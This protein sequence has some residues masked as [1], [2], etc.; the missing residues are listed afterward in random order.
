MNISHLKIHYIWNCKKCDAQFTELNLTYPSYLCCYDC[1]TLCHIDSAFYVQ[2][3]AKVPKLN[4]GIAPTE[5]DLLNGIS[6]KVY[7][8]S[9]RDSQNERRPDPSFSVFSKINDEYNLRMTALLV[10]EKNKLENKLIE[11]DEERLKNANCLLLITNLPED[12]AVTYR[13]IG[14]YNSSKHWYQMIPILKWNESIF[15]DYINVKK[16]CRD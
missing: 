9:G 8:L 4:S 11:L 14:D 7:R 10:G 12:K 15:L 6:A 1:G 16:G 5:R 13:A 2:D 3:S